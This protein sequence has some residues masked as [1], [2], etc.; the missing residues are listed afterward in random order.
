MNTIRSDVNTNLH[1]AKSGITQ[2]YLSPNRRVV[3]NSL[4]LAQYDSHYNAIQQIFMHTYFFK[5]LQTTMPD[6]AITLTDADA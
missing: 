6:T 1:F 4:F 5:L 3:F 2:H